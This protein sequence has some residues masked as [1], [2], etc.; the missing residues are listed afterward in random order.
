LDPLDILVVAALQVARDILAVAVLGT[1][2]AK[3][4]LLDLLSML[5]T[6]DTVHS[7]SVGKKILRYHWLEDLHIISK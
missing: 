3:A 1:L 2:E 6:A 7:L 5:L 4:T